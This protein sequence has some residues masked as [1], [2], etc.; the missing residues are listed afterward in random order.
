MDTGRECGIQ[1]LGETFGHD[2]LVWD[3]LELHVGLKS[4]AKGDINWIIAGG[5]WEGLP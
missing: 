2:Q 4:L 5:A 1:A 3:L